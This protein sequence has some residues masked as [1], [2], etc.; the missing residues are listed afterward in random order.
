MREAG[1]SGAEVQAALNSWGVSRHIYVTPTDS[2]A[3]REARA[4]ELWYQK[5]LARFLVPENIDAAP[6]SLQPQFRAIAAKLATVSW[7]GL[8]EETVLF[9]SPERIMDRVQEMQEA[10]VGELLCWMNFGGLPHD[11]VKR[12]M[13][14]FAEKVI[15][16]FR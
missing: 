8:L 1:Y 15:P 11:K 16:H 14:L 13:R 2:E 12:S 7:E 5:A 6:S 9:G 10:G 4:A 3:V